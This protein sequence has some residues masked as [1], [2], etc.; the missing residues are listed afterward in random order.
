MDFK[1]WLGQERS[2]LARRG[3]DFVVWPGETWLGGVRYGFRGMKRHGGA[4]FGKDRQGVEFLNV[5]RSGTAGA[6]SQM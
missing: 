5:A 1:V 4:K 3:M 6:A 2:G